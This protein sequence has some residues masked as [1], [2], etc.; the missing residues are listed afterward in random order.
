M[1]R[2]LKCFSDELRK[3]PNHTFIDMGVRVI[4]INRIKGSVDKCDELTS[5]FQPKK[6]FKL[7]SGNRQQ[8][9]LYRRRLL[10]KDREFTTFSPIQVYKLFGE[11]YVIDGNRRVA[12]SI[13]LGM[14]FIDA[15]VKEVVAG[16][17]NNN[18]NGVSARKR[19]EVEARISSID[20][21]RSTG[22]VILEE[23]IKKF[24]GDKPLPEKAADWLSEVFRPGCRTIRKSRLVELY[25]EESDGDIY[26]L[27]KSFYR[28]RPLI[29]PE[30][31]TMDMLISTFLFVK[32]K[33]RFRFYRIP[34]V[35]WFYKLL[36]RF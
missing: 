21:K 36:M 24:P 13:E 2:S 9:E 30:G 3:I 11:Y 31:H 32:G 35:R 18:V 25:P 14:E 19:L 4:A 17:E 16:G 8:A 12:A 27:V 1:K 10:I 22:Y 34:P 7:R 26:V 23:E 20:L 6:S 15:Y 5:R 28:D 33:K 29:R